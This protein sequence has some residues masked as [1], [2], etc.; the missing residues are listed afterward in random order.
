MTINSSLND[1]LIKDGLWKGYKLW[2]LYQ[3]A[4]TPFRWHKE[5]F[6][7]SKKIKLP[8]FS[9]PYDDE[10]VELLKKLKLNYTKSHHLK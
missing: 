8:C 10:G 2:D 6:N 5:L 4:Q 7:Y 9:T 1:F 3:E